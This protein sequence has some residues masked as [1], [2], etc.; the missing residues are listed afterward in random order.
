[1]IHATD[2]PAT[3]TL[4]FVY[5]TLKRGGSNHHYLRGQSFVGEARTVPGFRLYVV[6]DYPGMVPDAADTDGV[7]GEV[8][9]VDPAALVRLDELEGVEEGLYVREPARLRAPFTAQPVQT[10]RY[11]WSVVGCPWLQGG[12]WP[13]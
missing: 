3:S 5:G 11:L 1:M 8:W 13:T 6:A 7:A 4:V 12:V 10:Y 2:L 9:A